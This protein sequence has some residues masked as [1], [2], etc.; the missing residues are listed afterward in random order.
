MYFIIILFDVKTCKSNSVLC[1]MQMY[2]AML[3]IIKY[4]M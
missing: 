3:H 1:S 2:Y 4:I